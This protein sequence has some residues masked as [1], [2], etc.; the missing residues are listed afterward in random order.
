MA[1]SLTPTHQPL[2]TV[3]TPSPRLHQNRINPAAVYATGPRIQSKMSAHPPMNLSIYNPGTSKLSSP[4]T[5]PVGPLNS[6]CTAPRLKGKSTM[7]YNLGQS[8]TL[9]ARTRRRSRSNG[10]KLSQCL[11]PPKADASDDDVYIHSTGKD[12]KNLSVW[13]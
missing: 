11:S 12:P 5:R 9:P 2:R 3:Q 1:A 13:T 6:P 10:R 4:H 7:Y 8:A